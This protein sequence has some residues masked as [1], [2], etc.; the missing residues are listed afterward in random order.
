MADLFCQNAPIQNFPPKFI[1]P[2]ASQI[3]TVNSTNIENEKNQYYYL[4][5]IM[6]INPS[7]NVTTTI[8]STLE[9]I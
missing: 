9:F 2:L 4:P 7:D 5:S 8:E 1:S 6:D 3:I